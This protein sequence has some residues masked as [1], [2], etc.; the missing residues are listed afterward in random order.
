ME[1]TNVNLTEETRSPQEN[2]QPSGENVMVS[3][4]ESMLMSTATVETKAP[5]SQAFKKKQDFSLIAVHTGHISHNI[6]Q[7]NLDLKRGKLKS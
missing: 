7:T 5:D 1:T 6:L 4:G 2:S 3:L